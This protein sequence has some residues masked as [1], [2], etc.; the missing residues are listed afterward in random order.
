M[1]NLGPRLA[2]ELK[3]GRGRPG[4]LDW[5][6]LG[7]APKSNAP[8]TPDASQPASGRAAGG[9]GAANPP[10]LCA[11]ARSLARPTVCLFAC[12][13]WHACTGSL[14]RF[15]CSVSRARHSVG[16]GGARGRTPDARP[17]PP[18]MQMSCSANSVA[19]KQRL[20]HCGRPAPWILASISGGGGK[21]KAIRA[22]N[23]RDHSR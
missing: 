16:G 13:C 14:F 20:G 11:S 12:L 15:E 4:R 8:R 22:F 5:T 6:G 10:C 3:L 23:S 19:R 9:F 1:S 17:S 18:S 21:V 2:S 7:S